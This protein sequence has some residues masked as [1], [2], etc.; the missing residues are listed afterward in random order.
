MEKN[1]VRKSCDTLP[2]KKDLEHGSEELNII[3]YKLHCPKSI[4]WARNVSKY[5]TNIS[6]IWEVLCWGVEGGHTFRDMGGV[7]SRYGMCCVGG[8][9]CKSFEIWEVLFRDMGGAVWGVGVQTF[10]DMGGA[11]SRYERCCFNI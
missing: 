6:E 5:S 3:L 10:R 11:V 2:L 7:V 4:F 9:G 8:A 1:R